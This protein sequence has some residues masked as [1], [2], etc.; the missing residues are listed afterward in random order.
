LF[1]GRLAHVWC[2]GWHWR[3]IGRDPNGIGIATGSRTGAALLD[4]FGRDGKQNRPAGSGITGR[5]DV[6]PRPIL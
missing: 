4:Q 2:P 5:P 1:D 6:A 3:R